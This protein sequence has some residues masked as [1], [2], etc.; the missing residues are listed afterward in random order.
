MQ[1]WRMAVWNVWEELLEGA[2]DRK[3]IE[4]ERCRGVRVHS[5]EGLAIAGEFFR[6]VLGMV[7]LWLL[8]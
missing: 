1:L 3:G 8:S 2:N 7:E 4:Q 6:C 5:S